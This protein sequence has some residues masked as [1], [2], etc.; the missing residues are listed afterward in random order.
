[1]DGLM[2]AISCQQTFQMRALLLVGY[3]ITLYIAL[4]I[5]QQ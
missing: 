5:A 4:Y 3:C 2:D 1:M